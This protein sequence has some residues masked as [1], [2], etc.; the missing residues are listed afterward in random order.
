MKIML[1]SPPNILEGNVSEEESFDNRTTPLD[2][3]TLGAVLEKKHEVKILDALALELN[4]EKILQEIETFNPD[5]ICL[6]AFDRCRWGIDSANELS[7]Y[8]L[9]KNV[10]LIWAYKME[11]MIDSMKNNKNI[12]FAIYGDPEY[13]LLEIADKK[14]LK[15]IPGVIYRKGNKIIQNSPRNLIK[16]LDE[17]P[18]PSRNLLDF[19]AYKRL[20]HELI[21]SPSYDMIVSRGC[22][23]Q[24]AFCL[25]NIVGGRIRR[26][27]SPEKT[28][29]EMKLL[30]LMGAKQIHF[31][32]LTFT[33]ERNWTVEFCERLIKENLGLIWTCQTRVDK[34]DFELLKLMR[35][36]GC[37]SILY[38]IESL[39][40]DSLDLIHKNTS[41]ED[42]KNAILL[43]KKAGIE[44]RCS[45][46]I[47]LPGEKKESVLS[48]VN[49]LKKLNPAFVQFHTTMAL[50][51][52]ELYEYPERFKGKILTETLTK[53]FDISGKPFVPE[54]YKNEQE[55]LDLQKQAY[56][57]FYFRPK[58]ILGRIFSKNQFSR[59]IKG[60]KIFLK[61]LNKKN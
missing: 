22:P 55:I 45:M 48:T 31:Q 60:I 18:F 43:T 20:P 52:T 12:S 27:R 16:N 21:K 13:T 46:M 57:E 14:N 11:L 3:A 17:L 58:Y 8:I 50:P 61:L 4:K 36:A 7:K 56:K 10:G 37:R 38:G 39:V 29:E 2:L 1:I 24:C 15:D 41:V 53:K 25:M 23:Y 40:Q 35:K 51:G 54:D 5:L 49:L 19:N 34:V 9:N 59:N 28:V 30:R 26:Q 33:F 42:M 44:A 6:T 32:D 47:G